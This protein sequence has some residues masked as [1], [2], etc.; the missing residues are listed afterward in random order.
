MSATSAICFHCGPAAETMVV[1]DG[2]PVV[3]DNFTDWDC[4]PYRHTATGW[5]PTCVHRLRHRPFRYWPHSW[6]DETRLDPPALRIVLS[7]PVGHDR[8]I[9]VPISRQIHIA[10][11]AT[12]GWVWTDRDRLAWTEGDVDRLA[13]YD[14]L[15]ALGF[16]EVAITEPAPRFDVLRR[17]SNKQQVFLD[18][19]LLD[20]WRSRPDYLAVAARATRAPKEHDG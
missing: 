14:R 12:A 16:S 19:A 17:A 8:W 5:C 1:S 11:R 4:C 20:P 7:R 15:R 9:T 2:H 13:V 6:P 3:S 18:W 10:F